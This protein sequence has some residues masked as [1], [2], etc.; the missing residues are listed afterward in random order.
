M[1]EIVIVLYLVLPVSL[2]ILGAGALGKNSPV[3]GKTNSNM[4]I[5]KTAN[6][7]GMKNF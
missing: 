5:E 2:M 1:L 4:Q 3:A 6:G 7:N